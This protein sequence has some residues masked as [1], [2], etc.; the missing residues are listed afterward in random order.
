MG[1]ILL[2]AKDTSALDTA[3][4]DTIKAIQK[5]GL[6]ISEEKVQSTAPW[7]YLGY[8]ISSQTIQPQPL[9]INENPQ[10]LHDLKN[11][12]VPSTG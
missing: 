5:A 7:R 3:L 2:A 12:L 11:F 6:T 10:T 8:R 4:L 9:Q 1:N